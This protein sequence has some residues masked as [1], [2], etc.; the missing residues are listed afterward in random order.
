MNAG[1][2]ENII[3]ARDALNEVI[4]SRPAP[5]ARAL[6]LLSQAQRRLGESKEAE[7]TARRVI[8]QN[9]KS[10]W[11][12]YALAEALEERH[13]YQ[14]VVD[15]LAPVVSE[16]RGKSSDA[17]VDAG[18]LLP[19]L[20]FAYQEL[21]S[22]DKA[23]ATFEEAHKLAPDDATITA[24]LAQAHL[25]AKKFSAAI[26]VARKGRAQD[27][28]DLRFARL[29]A[30]AL[31]QSGKSDEAVSLLQEYVRKQADR[32]ESYVALAQLYSDAKRGGDAVKIEPEL[33]ESSSVEIMKPKSAVKSRY[34]SVP[35]ASSSKVRRLTMIGRMANSH[36][37]E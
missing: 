10:P 1:G 19:H 11:G 35:T 24:Y 32:P 14:S 26:D 6:Y 7:A 8:A 37:G 3:K 16:F 5:D 29:E 28:D 22:H 17:A 15:E 25:S 9:S 36:A 21:G 13:Q 4:A 30:Q 33:Y 34:T 31:R 20:G 27:A 2:R 23:I 12:Y 18:I